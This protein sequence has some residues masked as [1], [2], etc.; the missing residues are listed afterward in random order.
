[1]ERD[2]NRSTALQAGQYNTYRHLQVSSSSAYDNYLLLELDPSYEKATKYSRAVPKS[3]NIPKN[4]VLTK[5]FTII[6]IY[7]PPVISFIL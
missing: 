2:S 7:E 3:L 6:P 5:L 1:M 4:Y